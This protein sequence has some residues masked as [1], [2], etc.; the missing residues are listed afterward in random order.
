M[1][2]M[3]MMTMMM[4]MMMMNHDYDYDYDYDDHDSDY[5]YVYDCDDEDDDDKT[6]IVMI[7]MIMMNKKLLRTM[8]VILI[9]I[10]KVTVML[11][12][13]T[14]HVC[15]E[16]GPVQIPQLPRCAERSQGTA[17]CRQSPW[18]MVHGVHMD[19]GPWIAGDTP[20]FRKSPNSEAKH[21]Q[22][23]LINK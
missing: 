9:V 1:M 18:V 6:I 20:S 2:M 21:P 7:M 14:S 17:A 3:M 15:T 22:I 10:I 8:S 19:H 5:D 4:M 13:S 23:I 12:Y 11:C 16:L